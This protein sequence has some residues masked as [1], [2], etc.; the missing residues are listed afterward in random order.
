MKIRMIGTGLVLTLFL[1]ARSTGAEPEPAQ[2]GWA[3]YPEASSTQDVTPA[4][5]VAGEDAEN[6]LVFQS[7]DAAQ[8]AMQDMLDK[9]KDPEAR[10]ELRAEHRAMFERMH[11]DI[12]QE[13]G[14]DA[15]TKEK[16][17]DL[18][19]EHQ[20]REFEAGFMSHQDGDASF[21]M[22]ADAARQKLAS[23]RAL[24]GQDGV[25]E[26]HLYE[27]TTRERGQVKKVDSSLSTTQKLRPEQKKKLVQLFADSNRRA[28]ERDVQ[29]HQELFPLSEDLSSAE[30]LQR[31][32]QLLTIEANEA[33]LRAA[34][35]ENSRVE[36]QAAEFLSYVQVKALRRMQE[37]EVSQRRNWIEKERSRAGLSPQIPKHADQPL[38]P[39]AIPRTPIS[40]DMTLELTVTVNS[41]EPITHTQTVRNANPI[42]FDAGE[43]LW[44]EATPTIY[45]D[46]WLDV[47]LSFYEQIEGGRRPFNSNRSFGML[48]GAP[49]GT[50]RQAGSS[51]DVLT[52]S[53]VYAV[54]T[55]VRVR[56]P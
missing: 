21:L 32:S 15:T 45:E 41:R 54:K 10:A 30:A 34:L 22:Q 4:S 27:T 17:L 26:F 38:V 8:Q 44:I 18:L 3:P 2:G 19:A 9:L 1:A 55:S 7:G 28:L 43:G 11:A 49:N 35:E 24:L 20:L 39:K 14:I 48:L 23:L 56:W 12:E 25:D 6:A 31:R 52:G 53:E 5:P 46:H 50:F 16:L 33:A 13:L 36:R 29:A 51:N 47:R 37:E 42:L 40:G